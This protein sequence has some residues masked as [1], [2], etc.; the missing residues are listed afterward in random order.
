MVISLR[1][2]VIIAILIIIFIAQLFGF[3]YLESNI[4]SHVQIVSK[5]VCNRNVILY[6]MIESQNEKFNLER[7]LLSSNLLTAERI[8]IHRKIENVNIKYEN[9]ISEY[10]TLKKGIKESDLL[11]S[12][13][14]YY[15][16][17]RL[18]G[19]MII[20]KSN[21]IVDEQDT[22]VDMQME[23]QIEDQLI[24]NGEKLSKILGTLISLN[25]E[26]AL[27]EF[28]ESSMNLQKL[29]TAYFYV[30]GIGVLVS[31]LLG[32]ILTRSIVRPIMACV[33]FAERMSVGDLSARLDIVKTGETERLAN[34]LRTM[35]EAIANIEKNASLSMTNPGVPVRQ[36]D[37]RIGTMIADPGRDCTQVAAEASKEIEN[38]A[39]SLCLAAEDV[40]Q[41][42]EMAIESTRMQAISASE[43]SRVMDD[44]C[45]LVHELTRGTTQAN[46]HSARTRSKVVV[47]D[48]L[49]RR[50]RESIEK[51]DSLVKE[52]MED[53]CSFMKY[54]HSVGQNLSIIVD[55]AIQFKNLA[56][57]ASIEAGRIGR[58]GENFIIMMNKIV[59]ISEKIRDSAVK[60]ENSFC[61]VQE[62]MCQYKS[63]L[64][65][66]VLSANES[67]TL[68]H[69][70]T[71]SLEIVSSEAVTVLD[72]VCCV[73]GLDVE[74][75][76]MLNEVKHLSDDVA[77]ISTQV[78]HG[79]EESTMAF[80]Q[81]AKYAGRLETLLVGVRE[82][83]VDSSEEVFVDG[84][85]PVKILQ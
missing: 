8:N 78:M 38:E 32:Y 26:I 9:S 50:F 23:K 65:E 11:D 18:I 24:I 28:N 66:S 75:C 72:Q 44:I 52:L 77:L 31:I 10:K 40:C 69:E 36:Q 21:K 13:I 81:M 1:I 79:L 61:D 4:V 47:N 73:A 3:H 41:K 33:E 64:L 37:A 5:K 16:K 43:A 39:L 42:M 56:I 54:S 2:A 62:R 57:D 80:R 20:V 29:N 85:E 74:K 84:S 70:S 35:A 17:S 60:V 83:E 45:S 68:V 55:I 82:D 51:T 14:S 49:C 7:S 59:R 46:V 71:L 12:Y 34:C 67:S 76:A 25:Y 15:D 27:E 6:S 22:P 53:L 63:K 48:D 19:E 30:A 58:F